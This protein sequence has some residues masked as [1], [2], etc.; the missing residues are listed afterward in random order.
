MG[1]FSPD[2][3]YYSADAD[4][5]MIFD[6]RTGEPVALDLDA[7][8][9]TAFEWLDDTTAVVLASDR[10]AG[11]AQASLWTCTV[12]SGEC[13]PFAEDLGTFDELGGGGFA[14]PVGEPL[15]D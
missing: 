8:F 7:G 4:E 10:P 12:P 9:A 11:D 1:S 2:A 6:T 3:G 14:L 15:G 5:P 13:D